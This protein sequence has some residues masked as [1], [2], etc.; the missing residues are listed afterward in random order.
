MVEEEE[1]EEKTEERI[2]VSER[3][4]PVPKAKAKNAKC[5][6]RIPGDGQRAPS[7]STS[8]GP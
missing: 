4:S 5:Q 7:G 6:M 8:R 2:R 1:E 3:R